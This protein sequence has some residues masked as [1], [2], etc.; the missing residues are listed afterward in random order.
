MSRAARIRAFALAVLVGA[1]A[2]GCSDLYYDRRDTISLGAGDAVA[3]NVAT[4]TIDVWPPEA[5]ETRIVSNG[6]KIQGAVERYRTNKVIPPVGTGTSSVGYAP[7]QSGTAAAPS[8][9]Q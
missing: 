1:S 8:V 3:T 2:A 7:V 5:G 9:S 6:Q 4:H